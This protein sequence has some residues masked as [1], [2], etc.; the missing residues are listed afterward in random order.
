MRNSRLPYAT[1]VLVLGISS[2]ALCCCYGLPGIMTGII[3]LILYR[4]DIRYYEKNKMQ[5]DNLDSLKTG[6]K[7]SI[8]GI[9]MSLV[10]I[11]YLIFAYYIAGAEAFS[12]PTVIWK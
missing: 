6:R 7:L 3:A 2:I 9:S 1:A 12:D 11:L 4:K 10:Y 5:Y 8:I